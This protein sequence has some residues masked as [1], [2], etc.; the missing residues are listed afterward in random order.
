MIDSG[1]KSDNNEGTDDLED[2]IE[3]LNISEEEINKEIL[4]I[5]NSLNSSQSQDLVLSIVKPITDYRNNFNEFE[6]NILT[7]LMNAT[8][9]MKKTNQDQKRIIVHISQ[10][11][12]NM[13]FKQ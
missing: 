2:I 12:N 7:E 8:K 6:G 10:L 13:E 9:Y 3:N 5:E 1:N 11:I 4:E